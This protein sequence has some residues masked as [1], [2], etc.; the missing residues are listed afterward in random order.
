MT[1]QSLLKIISGF[2]SG[3]TSLAPYATGCIAYTVQKHLSYFELSRWVATTTGG[4][5]ALWSALHPQ[6][7]PCDLQLAVRYLFRVCP[8]HAR[9]QP[10]RFAYVGTLPAPGIAC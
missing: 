10:R 5:S 7:P 1:F 4:L 6:G 2:N 9:V 3:I 8:L